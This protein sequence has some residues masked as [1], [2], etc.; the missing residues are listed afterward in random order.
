[1]ILF[2]M[3]VKMLR[4]STIA[5]DWPNPEGGDKC[6]DEGNDTYIYTHTYIYMYT[7]I[8]IYSS[9]YIYIYIIVFNKGFIYA[10]F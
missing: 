2:D 7:Y 9:I 1:M 6:F 5:S 8:H 3:F 4:Y 10:F